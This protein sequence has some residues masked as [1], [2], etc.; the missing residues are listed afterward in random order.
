MKRDGRNK[1]YFISFAFSNDAETEM[2]HLWKEG[3]MDINL[4][5]VN[6]RLKSEIYNKKFTLTLSFVLSPET[7]LFFIQGVQK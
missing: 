4:I 5:K 7:D 6:S 3:D 1:G 2:K